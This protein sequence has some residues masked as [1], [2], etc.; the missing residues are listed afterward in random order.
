MAKPVKYPAKLRKTLTA[1]PQKREERAKCA[2]A[3]VQAAE[4]QR[5]DRIKREEEEAA[6]PSLKEKRTREALETIGAFATMLSGGFRR[7]GLLDFDQPEK[8][9]KGEKGGSCNRHACQK[10]GAWW[11]NRSTER[12]YCED[13]ARLINDYPPTQRDSMRLYGDPRLC[14]PVDAS[15]RPN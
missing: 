6:D 10:P 11:F 7:H 5:L 14:V 8:A 12:F 2:A 3:K 13:C 15:C 4:Q 1:L 9:D